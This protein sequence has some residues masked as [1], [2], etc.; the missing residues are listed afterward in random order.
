MARRQPQ[1]DSELVRTWLATAERGD[2]VALKKMARGASLNLRDR[3][4]RGT[5][6]GWAEYHRHDRAAAFLRKRAA[7]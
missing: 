5:P 2:L 6:V 1:L 4:Y 3:E 7:G